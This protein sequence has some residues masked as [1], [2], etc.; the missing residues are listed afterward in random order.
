[1]PMPNDAVWTSSTVID[2]G[3]KFWTGIFQPNPQ[4]RTREPTRFFI[5]NQGSAS[6]LALVT[7]R[8]VTPSHRG[9]FLPRR[10]ILPVDGAV[11][12]A[13]ETLASGV[14]PTAS[15]R[16]VRLA[17]VPD[18]DLQKVSWQARTPPSMMYFVGAPQAGR[19]SEDNSLS[20]QNKAR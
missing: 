13:P 20:S 14:E 7:G 18:G 5:E 9:L 17:R 10:T 2:E 4:N 15:E 11:I 1:M 16:S 6:A 8:R 19:R 12:A 3:C